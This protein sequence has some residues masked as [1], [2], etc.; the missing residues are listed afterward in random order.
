MGVMSEKARILC[1]HHISYLWDADR[2]IVV[3]DGM[4][5][6]CGKLVFEHWLV[7]YWDDNQKQI[8]KT[9]LPTVVIWLFIISSY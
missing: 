9:G 4:I 5:T 7:M 6:Q 8:K 1:T 3:E 2:I